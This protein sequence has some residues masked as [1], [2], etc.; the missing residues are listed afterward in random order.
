MKQIISIISLYV[1]LIFNTFVFAQQADTNIAKVIII[2][3]SNDIGAVNVFKII[4]ND[5]LPIK[6]YNNSYYSFYTNSKFLHYKTDIENSEDSLELSTEESNYL[7]LEFTYGF[8]KPKPNIYQIQPHVGHNL[9]AIHQP[10]NMQRPIKRYMFHAA[11]LFGGGAGFSDFNVIKT[12][13]N[14][15][16]TFGFGGGLSAGVEFGIEQSKH[17]DMSFGYR[18]LQRG[19]SP[20]LQN[21]S[22]EFSRHVFS[23]IPS[24]ILPLNEANMHRLRFGIGLDFYPSNTLKVKTSDL[25]NG[26][27]DTWQYESQVGYQAKISYEMNYTD[28]LS[29]LICT[30]YVDVAHEFKSGKRFFPTDLKFINPRGNGIEV[31]LGVQYHF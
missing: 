5:T 16:V 1:F 6:L 27:D 21:A 10:R 11:L 8:W 31:L 23:V 13:D 20:T 9:M 2:R 19:L 15:D 17:F 28:Q 18:Y 29:F 22:L 4:L 24:F 30:R 3:P 12:T 25:Q 26:I 14:Q 7:L